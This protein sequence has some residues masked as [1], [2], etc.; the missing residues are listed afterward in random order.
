MV[1]ENLVDSLIKEFRGE[2]SALK[3]KRAA[4]ITERA[5]TINELIKKKIESMSEQLKNDAINEVCGEDLDKID[6]EMEIIEAKLD[7]LFSI[8]ETEDTAEENNIEEKQEVE[9]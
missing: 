4:I 3:D 8:Q 5:V 6:R 2:F 7:V 1:N 9:E